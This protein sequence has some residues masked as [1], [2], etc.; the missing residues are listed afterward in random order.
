[1]DALWNEAKGAVG[2]ASGASPQGRSGQG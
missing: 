1:M 2:P